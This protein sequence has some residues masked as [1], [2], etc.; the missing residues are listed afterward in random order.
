MRGARYVLAQLRGR[1][2]R[3]AA[4]LGGIVIA[5]ASLGVLVSTARTQNLQVHGTLGRSFRSSYDIL[6]RPKGSQ[7][8]MERREGLVRD[9]FLSGIFGGITMEQYQQI[10]KLPGVQVAAPIA[11]IGYLLQSVQSG[12]NGDWLTV[13]LEP[14]QLRASQE[15]F[16]VQ[17]RR[18]TDRGLVRL[19]DA[20]GYAYVTDRP[21]TVPNSFGSSPYFGYSQRLASGKSVLVCPQSN[22]GDKVPAPFSRIVRE[23][24]LDVCV[25]QRPGGG[26][27]SLAHG[28]LLS[29][30][31]VPR[32]EHYGGLDHVVVPVLAS[33]RPYV[34][35]ADEVTV[36]RLSD[37]AAEVHHGRGVR[38]PAGLAHRPAV[39]GGR[40]LLDERPDHLPPDRSAP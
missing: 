32:M 29:Q 25:S 34:D 33:T 39:P 31:A 18:I 37:R 12:G 20:R 11:M 21:L 4:L 40:Q 7:T 5:C 13:T 2:A 3:T 36:S 1:G 35:D 38:S 16:S 26:V 17:V 15:L 28:R 22:V 10:A 24:F 27:L 9:N 14:R 23:A 8:P 6:V 30:R 19:T